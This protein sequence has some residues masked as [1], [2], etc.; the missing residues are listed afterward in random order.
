MGN[1]PSNSTD[2]VHVSST[3]GY[4][5]EPALTDSCQTQTCVENLEDIRPAAE[6][7]L[8]LIE[9]QNAALPPYHR[10]V[11]FTPPS[12]QAG[13]VKV[14]LDAS[15]LE[16]LADQP[17]LLT[18]FF[19]D[20]DEYEQ[21]MELLQQGPVF[22]FGIMRSHGYMDEEG[23]L[24]GSPSRYS[25]LMFSPSVPRSVYPK[26]LMVEPEP[27]SSFL[28][29]DTTGWEPEDIRNH[30]AE[31]VHRRLKQRISPASTAWYEAFSQAKRNEDFVLYR[32]VAI[33]FDDQPIKIAYKARKPGQEGATIR[34]YPIT[35][36]TI[37]SWF[38]ADGT[39]IQMIS[40]GYDAD[41]VRELDVEPEDLPGL[42]ARIAQMNTF[43]A[44]ARL[45]KIGI[46]ETSRN[47]T[48]ILLMKK[49]QETQAN[50]DVLTVISGNVDVNR[51]VTMPTDD[52][53]NENAREQKKT[54]FKQYVGRPTEFSVDSESGPFPD[55]W[56]PHGQSSFTPTQVELPDSLQHHV[57]A[58]QGAGSAFYHQSY[59]WRPV[60][61]DEL[62]LRRSKANPWQELL[63][64]AEQTLHR[65]PPNNLEFNDRERMPGQSRDGIADGTQYKYFANGEAQP[66]ILMNVVGGSSEARDYTSV[67]FIHQDPKTL[68]PNARIFL[69]RDN[70]PAGVHSVFVAE[71]MVE[72]DALPAEGP[73]RYIA[74]E[75]D[76]TVDIGTKRDPHTVTVRAYIVYEDT[77]TEDGY[78]RIAKLFIKD[79]TS[80]GPQFDVGNSD[81]KDDPRLISREYSDD[82]LEQLQGVADQ[83]T[84]YYKDATA[85]A[86]AVA[87]ADPQETDK[88]KEPKPP[89][90][91]KPK[92][93][94]DVPAFALQFPVGAQIT[95]AQTEVLVPDG[96]DL[97][98][99]GESSATGLGWG[100]VAAAEGQWAPGKGRNF[101][102]HGQL[103]ALPSYLSESGDG[104]TYQTTNLDLSLRAY[105]SYQLGPVGVGV[106]GSGNILWDLSQSGNTT[107]NGIDIQDVEM[108]YQSVFLP[109]LDFFAQWNQIRAGVTALPR[110]NNVA[111]GNAGANSAAIGTNL[112]H[113]QLTYIL[114]GGEE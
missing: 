23:Y 47:T 82:F 63:E 35:K 90:E 33:H 89:R 51:Q 86:P 58:L 92:E 6:Q 65:R 98:A 94:S 80:L 50:N 48:T 99:S 43:D 29:A 79:Y 37:E 42:D 70:L 74:V 112:T 11:K 59:P 66:T 76:L 13:F 84:Q 41:Y 109:G 78:Q 10:A 57:E 18:A 8:Q 19:K 102:L 46:T 103:A 113:V 26:E 28:P 30:Q 45:T 49:G 67:E 38:L 25:H 87:A 114:G 106:G 91:R 96:N 100:V 107:T 97:V 75:H 21:A 3:S 36:L 85:E 16:R 81:S 14:K 77:K 60:K 22:D 56:L 53:P 4:Q 54:I 9:T 7:L 5:P 64:T 52:G 105:A 68:E 55:T 24:L 73:F 72:R 111:T 88:P 17:N 32:D 1:G 61:T 104:A 110:R 39:Q 108:Q 93:P 83:S 34:I 40:Y 62:Y 20:M 15:D 12:Q 71:R 69:N 95:R 2:H 44:E 101:R 27:L 31:A